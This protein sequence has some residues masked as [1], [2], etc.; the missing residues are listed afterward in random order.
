MKGRVV[1]DYKSYLDQ[2]YDTADELENFENKQERKGKMVPRGII[3]EKRKQRRSRF[4]Y[5]DS[6]SDG[7]LDIADDEVINQD[8][9]GSENS[10][11]TDT[12]DIN[13]LSV[14]ASKFYSIDIATILLL[15]PARLPAFSLE[16]K[17]W[18]WL[19]VDLLE[20]VK[21]KSLPFESLQMEHKTKRLIKSL[22]MGHK[23]KKDPVFD[24][25]IEGK[26]QGLIFL[27]HGYGCENRK[28]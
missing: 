7:G 4:A 19:L 3:P 13:K 20:P 11:D 6:E 17:A 26:G 28:P 16:E 18:G 2:Y 10:T 14:A 15:F 25:V 8:D 24:D 21:W 22:V 27:L 23:N 1:V 12:G 5:S 9:M